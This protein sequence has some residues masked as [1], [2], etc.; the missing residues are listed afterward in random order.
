MRPTEIREKKVLLSP[1][2]WGMG[3]VSRCIGL[4]DQ[5][6]KQGNEVVILC[7]DEQKHIFISY[8]PEL[9]YVDL[10]GYPFDFRGKGKFATDLLRNWFKLKGHI[11]KERA[12]I[13]ALVERDNFDVVISDHRYGCYAEN[14]PSVFLTHQYHLPLTGIQ[15]IADRW[16]KK[17]MRPFDHIWILDYENSQLSG[18]LTEGIEDDRV[19]FI[20]PLSRF[21]VYSMP[22]TKSG[23][24]VV[25]VSGPHIYAQQ[26]VNQMEK[27]FPDALFICSR[28]ITTL[29]QTKRISGDWKEQ[30]K[31]ILHA[32]RLISRS[33]YSTLLDLEILKIPA[34]LHPTP[35]QAEQIYLHHRLTDNSEY[36]P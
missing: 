10:E 7:N 9:H 36:T 33:G 23:G 3:H 1:L 19:E 29:P 16:H 8:F 24:D 20:G 25:V 27:Q 30:D 17:R 6:L 18:R 4:V 28:E 2:N 5:L 13:A 26:F 12:L 22:K 32:K 35:G 21:S 14:I 31:A 15:S 11:Y 34:L